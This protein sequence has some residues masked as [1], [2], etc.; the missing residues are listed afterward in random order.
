MVEDYKTNNF[1]IKIIRVI[2]SYIEYV[3]SNV[4]KKKF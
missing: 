2:M 3:N 4:W 1:S